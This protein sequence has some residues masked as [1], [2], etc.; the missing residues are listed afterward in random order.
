MIDALIDEA[1][2]FEV[3][4]AFYDPGAGK[5]VSRLAH[6]VLL[7]LA[8][9]PPTSVSYSRGGAGGHSLEVRAGPT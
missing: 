8:I 9:H 4:G 1:P 5:T 6:P 7:T 3:D 2:L